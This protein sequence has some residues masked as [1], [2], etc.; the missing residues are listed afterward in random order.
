MILGHIMFVMFVTFMLMFM[1]FMMMNLFMLDFFLS[2]RVLCF[3]LIC[4]A[5]ISNFSSLLLSIISCVIIKVGFQFTFVIWTL[6]DFMLNIGTNGF[7]GVFVVIL[8][9]MSIMDLFFLLV[10]LMGIYLVSIYFWH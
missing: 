7:M 3:L 5:V 8:M 2:M 6:L 10:C 9:I 1:G 4:M